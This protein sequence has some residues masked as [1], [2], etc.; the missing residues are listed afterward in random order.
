MVHRIFAFPR[1]T[2]IV[3]QIGITE[4]TAKLNGYILV[5]EVRQNLA[6]E[7]ERKGKVVDQL[8]HAIEE[9]NEDGRS[10]LIGMLLACC[11][12]TCA[13]LM[14]RIDPVLLDQCHKPFCSW[15]EVPLMLR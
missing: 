14:A 4:K 8:V 12:V 10:L 6:V 5:S 15:L 3:Y 11:A 7:F 1:L 9:L 13:E 2:D